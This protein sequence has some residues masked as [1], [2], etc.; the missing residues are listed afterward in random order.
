MLEI[1]DKTI[2]QYSI[3]NDPKSN[4]HRAWV[5]LKKSISHLSIGRL[6]IAKHGKNSICDLDYVRKFFYK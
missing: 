2:E 1:D 3:S 4:L 6:A 5:I